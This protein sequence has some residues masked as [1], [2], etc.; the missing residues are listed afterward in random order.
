MKSAVVKARPGDKLRLSKI[1]PD[2]TSGM[3]KKEA[4]TRFVDLREEISLFQEKLFAEHQ[5][6]L[7]ILFQAMDTGGKDGALKALCFG[8][9]PAGLKVAGLCAFSGKTLAI[10]RFGSIRR[11]DDRL[12]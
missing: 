12:T 1:A 4:C 10:Q 8:L 5:R 2:D 9:N 11:Q 3:S 7:L 6:S